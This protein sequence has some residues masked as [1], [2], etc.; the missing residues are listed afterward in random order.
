MIP[1]D[2]SSPTA[3]S[4]SP[5]TYPLV[6]DPYTYRVRLPPHRHDRHRGGASRQSHHPEIGQTTDVD[7]KRPAAALVSRQPRIESEGREGAG[8]RR[9]TP[10]GLYTIDSR[11]AYS[12]YHM[13]LHVSYPNAADR[14]VRA[15]CTCRPGGAIMIHGTPNR[16]RGLRFVFEHTDW[17]AGCIA[18]S[19]ARSRRSGSWFRTA[20]SWRFGREVCELRIASRH[21]AASR[22]RDAPLRHPIY[23]LLQRSG[24]TS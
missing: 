11:N 15:G 5:F 1:V 3:T 9:R 4:D 23:P 24:G 7:A 21:N 8:G 14:F 16:W 22:E 10:E 20:R 13:A 2:G 12:K 6:G 19:D 17:T 18:V